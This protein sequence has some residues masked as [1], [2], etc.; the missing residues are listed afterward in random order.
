MPTSKPPKSIENLPLFL[1]EIRA[2][3]DRG[4]VRLLS[5]YYLPAFYEGN[6]LEARRVID[7]ITEEFRT[8]FESCL[9]SR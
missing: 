3:W 5:R 8:L 9:P 6:E 2:A 4:D 1:Q 7:Y